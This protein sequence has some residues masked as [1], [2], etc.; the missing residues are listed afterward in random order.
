MRLL[1]SQTLR[2]LLAGFL[3]AAT[4]PVLAAVEYQYT[5]LERE[6]HDPEVFTQGFLI[7]DGWFYESSGQYGRSFLL[8]YPL[9]G[10]SDK[11]PERL[12]LPRDIFAEGLAI[13]GNKLVLLSWKAGRAWVLDSRD[14]RLLKELHYSGE[15]WGLTHNG[16]HFILSD[17]TDLLRFYDDDFRLVDTLKVRLDGKAVKQLNELEYHDGLIWAN[18]W[19][20]DTIYAIDAA[21]GEVK[22]TV[23]LGDLQNRSATRS[24]ESVLNG[25]AYD[26]ERDAF[27][28]TGK[29]WRHRYLLKFSEPAP[30]Q[31]DR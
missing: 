12:A 23:D 1:T 20:T 30:K 6:R 19:M 16:E 15:G 4:A 7:H 22:A 21:S 10:K 27:W 25:I 31:A 2:C 9:D 13:A 5:V 17:G 24:G 29:Y 3:L 14:F 26:K 8:R 28:I 11:K 18:Q